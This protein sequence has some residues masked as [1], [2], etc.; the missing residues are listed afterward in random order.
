MYVAFA[1]RA[2]NL[3]SFSACPRTRDPKTKRAFSSGVCVACFVG[4]LSWTLESADLGGTSGLSAGCV[5]G[6]WRIVS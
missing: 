5:E 6:L 4:N 2:A 1:F 3:S